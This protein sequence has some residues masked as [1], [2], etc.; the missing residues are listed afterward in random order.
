M[1]KKRGPDMDEKLQKQLEF[2]HEIDKVK[3]II[4]KTRI[5]SEDRYEN[6]AEHSWHI[7]IMAM[8]L[9]EYSN[10]RIDI[11]RVVKML[12]IHDL[13]EIDAGDVIVYEKSKEHSKKELEAAHRI[14]GLLPGGQDKEFLDI[15]MEFEDRQTP[16]A[17]FAATVDRLEPLLQNIHRDGAD[18]HMNTITYEQ[19]TGNRD[20]VAGGSEKLWDYIKNEIDKCMPD[21]SGK[22]PNG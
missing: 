13:V 9:E 6:D 21:G 15:W 19:I 12:L 16:E 3:K 7:C 8:V 17:R 18:W 14:F 1:F 22:D 2:I 20:E 11:S 10:K 5:F 4:R